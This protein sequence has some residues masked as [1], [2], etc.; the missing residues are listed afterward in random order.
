[1]W[2]INQEVEFFKLR[3]S[4]LDKEGVEKLLCMHK[5]DCQQ[6]TP[7]EKDELKEE[8]HSSTSKITNVD[9]V[10]FYK[11]PFR[12]VTDLIK[13]RKVYISQ[14][15]AYV[16]H[17]DL[18]SVFVSHFRKNMQN[19]M[20]H[21]RLSV[22]NVCDDERIIS[23]LDSLPGYFAGMTRVVWTTTTT[24]IDKLNEL[25]KSSYPMC[26]RV[27]HEALKNNHHLRNSGRIQY[28]LFL[29]GIGV[30]MEDSMNFWKTE[31]TKKL[32]VD[33]FE[34]E[35]GYAIRH[36]YGKEGKQ[37]NYTPLGCPKIIASSVGPGEYHGCPYKHMDHESLRQKLFSFGL[38]AAN[39]TEIAELAKDWHYNI[40]C[41]TYF[42][43]LHNNRLPE[44]PVIHPNGYFLES[45]NIMAK[46]SP[47]EVEGKERQTQS[48]SQNLTQSGRLSDKIGTPNR[49]DR[50]SGTPLRNIATPSRSSDRTPT[51]P[52][53]RID[54]TSMMT[55]VKSVKATPKR[56]EN[57]LNDDEIA[58]LMS[59]DM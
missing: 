6:I 56:I 42:K 20:S 46:D 44:K 43:A 55:P 41:T 23:F 5:I 39:I 17:T 48:S 47:T 49:I 59:E 45:R 24:P 54:R 26:M 7:E 25:S 57:H 37:T 38:S 18:V 58:E 29:K 15:I 34:K 33:K 35:Y 52:M 40:A 3:F 19:G 12:K 2:F 32:D 51:T 13:S 36:L 9:I 22:S 28:G 4:S 10:E 27:L 11:V 21:A 31:F 53:R 16:P 50:N 14:G 30:T 1:M 8:L